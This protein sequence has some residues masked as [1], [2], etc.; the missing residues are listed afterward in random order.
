[1]NAKRS[2]AKPSAPKTSR[3]KRQPAQDAAAQL[4]AS[5]FDALR[6]NVFI[7]NRDFQIVAIN[8]CAKDTLASL[9]DEVK[10]IFGVSLDQML[11][12]SIHRF[13]RDA[14]RVE[15]ILTN[16]QALP[17]EAE[18]TFGK[19]ILQTRI[20]S[21]PGPDGKPDGYVV[22]WDDI[23]Y[24]RHI[25][26]EHKG[27]IDAIVRSQDV[28][29]FTL[30]GIISSANDNFLKTFG[31]AREELVGKHYSALIDDETRASAECREL[32]QKLNRGEYHAGE[33]R[34]L[35]KGGR[36][37]FIQGVYNP[38]VDSTGKPWKVVMYAID[39]TEETVRRADYEAQINAISKVRAVVEFSLD[40]TIRSANA[41]FLDAMGYQLEEIQGRQHRMFVESSYGA[42]GEYRQF[43]AN[44]AAGEPQTGRF[45]RFGKNGR[46]VWIEG[47]YFPI[48]DV[49]GKPCKVVKYAT[50]ITRLKQV[51][52]S[53]DTTA[54]TLSSAAQELTSVSQLMASNAEETASQA[55]VV[56]AAADQVSRNVET[57]A[58]SMNEMGASI[59]EIA[60]N[61][62]EAARIAM[63]A[64]KV[65]DKTNST[66]SKLGESSAEI[67]NVIK[68]I[69]SI[70][71]QTNLLALNATIEAARAGEAGKGFAVVANEVKEL[72]KQTARATEDI[73]RKIDAIQGDTKGAVDAI[74]QIGQIIGQINDIQ[75]TIASAVEEQT[76]TTAEITRN[77][78]EAALGSRE[79]AQN[80]SGVAQAA[81]STTEGAAHT[82]SSADD[83]ARLAVELQQLV[84]KLEA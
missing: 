34:C 11:G 40:G 10:R 51:E 39:V 81:R 41:N 14:K 2:T 71:Q 67:G 46:E 13:H 61:S 7:A 12:S 79:I 16:P 4:I 62:S 83:L 52:S 42:S 27:Q 63:A 21:I 75:S 54:Q 47:S 68:V 23:T 28:I 77:V 32:W 84:R 76:A 24:R 56:S 72:A 55:N 53:L 69:T 82:K 70:A 48:L 8:K 59:K 3:A 5:S 35:G 33:F 15:Q 25:E 38:I 65:A 26:L 37:V 73:G 60:K 57:V 36:Q 18:F 22:V 50:D 29:E 30:D 74:G 6:A 66:V 49:C 80:V 1:M 17:H 31:Y 19:I 78:E 20:N 45:R 44:L 43:W 9:A 64:V 58:S